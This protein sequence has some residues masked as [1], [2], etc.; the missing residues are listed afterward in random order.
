M[1]VFELNHE[2]K[3][4]GEQAAVLCVEVE[5]ENVSERLDGVGFSTCPERDAAQRACLG[6]AD[7]W[8]DFART[9]RDGG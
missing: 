5:T 8:C 1:G 4:L 9:R 2:G 3:H 6:D 7:Y